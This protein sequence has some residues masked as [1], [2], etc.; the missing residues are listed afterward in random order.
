MFLRKEVVVAFGRKQRGLTKVASLTQDPEAALRAMA[1]ET[2][3]MDE[4]QQRIRKDIFKMIDQGV[5]S[6]TDL[7][8]PP[9]MKIK[10]DS[11]EMGDECLAIFTVSNWP[12]ELSYGWLNRILDDPNLTDVKMDVSMHIH[13]IRKDYAIA[14]MQ[15]K[16]ISAQSSAEMEMEKQ[17]IK[18]ANQKIY[19]KQMDTA[20]MIRDMLDSGAENLFQVSLIFGVY[21]ENQWDYD[22]EGNEVLIANQHE[23]LVEKTERVKKA[24]RDNSRGEFG[25]KSLLHQQRDGI[26]SLLP[27]GYGGL[28]SFQNFY[29]SALATCYPFTNG[30][31]QVEDGILYGVSMASQQP[32]FFD[33]FN[34]DWVKSYNCIIIGAK[35]SGKSATAKTLLGRYAIKGTQIFVIDPAITS[36]GEYTNLAI[37]LDGTLV[38]FGG[39]DGVYINPFELTPPTKPSPEPEKQ[40][41][42]ASVIYKDKKSYLIGLFELMRSIYE[43]EN[44]QKFK[45]ESF[46]SVLQ[47]LIDRTYQYKRIRIG[48]NRWNFGEWRPETM[49]TIVDFYA[50]V[51]EYSRIVSTFDDREKLK[52]WG[53][54]HLTEQGAQ[55]NPNDKRERIIFGYYR[56]VINSG[57]PLWKQDE[58]ATILL[59]KKILTEYIPNSDES[60]AGSSKSHLFFGH[61]QTDLSNQCIVF[62]F[63]KCDDTI[64]GLATYICFE[65]INSRVRSSTMSQFKNKIVVLDEAWKMIQSGMARKYLEALYREGRKQNTG[66][67]LIS[68][69]YEDFQGDNDI[70]FKY[71]ETKLI[72]S[73]PD[74]EVTQLIEEIELSSSMTGIINEKEG[75]TAPGMGIL[76]IGGGNEKHETVS[77]YCQMTPLELAI[78]DTAD[79]NKPPLTASQILGEQRAKELGLA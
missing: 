36:Q 10:Y 45:T 24:L 11:I 32:I 30:S 50:I 1:Q 29:T 54:S 31:L 37:S 35:G 73:I 44:N 58:L 38:D 46:D 34:R 8:A 15:D 53:A 49:P 33:I 76:H 64:K 12:T 68:Q 23:D 13:P 75:H 19:S 39:E 42:Q 40:N 6:I 7:W 67:W 26:K 63:G 61:K 2:E 52:A 5:G 43:E 78:A 66:I 17:K 71:A 4:E 62:R 18:E 79:A 72:M 41:D 56:S 28:H 59:L 74:E 14:Y 9:R 77:F 3:R 51:D 60:A 27:L 65:L 16:F 21:G 57:N 70:F 22:E 48:K 55:K 25:V 47:T 69:S 20:T